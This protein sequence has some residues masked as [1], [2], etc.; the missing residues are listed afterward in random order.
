M[1]KALTWLLIASTAYFITGKLGLLLAIPPGF[2]SAI[3]PA[4]GV[5]LACVLMGH[6]SAAILGLGLGS[7]LINLSLASNNF[8]DISTQG[9]LTAAFIASGAMTQ[10]G[11]GA[12]LFL[13]LLGSS[14]V[15][16]S[17]KNIIRFIFVIALGTSLIAATI[18]V[19]TL[20][21][22]DTISGTN[23]TFS[24]ITWWI[25]D[26]I[27]VVL[28]TPLILTFF[29]QQEQLPI[30]RKW[31]TILPTS[32]IFIGVL[33]LFTLSTEKRH[34][35]MEAEI[36]EAGQQFFFQ[37]DRNLK[38]GIETLAAYSG[39]FNA[40]TKVSW[41][42]FV[43]FS[44]SVSNQRE[45]FDGVGWTEIIEDKE[46]STFIEKIRQEFLPNFNIKEKNAANE[47]ITAIKRERYFPVIYIYPLETNA[48]AVGFN[49]GSKESRL[50]TLLH[51]K[52]SQTP[53][54]TPPIRLV[55]EKGAGLSTIIYYPV[56]RRNYTNNADSN[57]GTFLGYISGVIRIQRLLGDLLDQVKAN[58]F[59]LSLS[60][61][62]DKEQSVLIVEPSE[63]PLQGFLPVIQKFDF[64]GRVYQVEFFANQNFKLTSKDWASFMIL[65]I[66]FIFAAI[67]QA[68]ILLLTGRTESIKLEVA[69]KT[70][71]LLLATKTAEKASRA[72]SEFTANISHELRTPLN[73]IIGLINQCL[74][75]E[76]NEKQRDCLSKARL[77]SET[78]TGIINST[79]DFSKIEAGKLELDFT[80][81]N[82]PHLLNKIAAIF[83]HKAKEG[84]LEFAIDLP[85]SIPVML[86]GDQ[87]RL[88]QIL[89]N[90]LGNAFKF[91]PAGE[92]RLKI[93]IENE[94]ESNTTIC[95]QVIDT[96]IGIPA[97]KQASMFE[98]FHQVDSSTSRKF[99]GTGLGLTISKKLLQ[100]MNSDIH[101]KGQEN[102]GSNFQFS[103]SFELADTKRMTVQDFQLLND[104][105]S[106][107]TVSPAAPPTVL[108]NKKILVVEDVELNQVIVREILKEYQASVSLAG[109]GREA[110]E[111]L[112]Q[113]HNFDLILM[114]IQMP[115]MDGY[116]AT[117]AIREDPGLAHLPI[118]AMT[119]NA[120]KEDVD[121]CLAAGMNAHIAK[122][123]DEKILVSRIIEV[124]SSNNP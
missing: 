57:Q 96:G 100:L 102:I 3:W 63:G 51:A 25:G 12:C 90:L 77:A 95:F 2:A 119:A 75:T 81:F 14:P 112:Q 15:I 89:L 19:S 22:F 34:Q 58:Q 56:I 8:S 26:S 40:S 59:D 47:W 42:E 1:K 107:K 53:Q 21:Q 6:R 54:A 29:S 13:R 117:Q 85:N 9:L 49:L 65:T 24:W 115:E 99:G 121:Q 17:P 45:I 79:L 37:F 62:T 32:L 28:F 55:Q 38:A 84:E 16:D 108:A 71:D 91:T 110:L 33:V 4:S 44:L 73:A 11:V 5:A 105:L 92:V 60:D 27:G 118:I 61:I 114:D 103:I 83:G 104:A 124:L 78:L 101:Y 23:V 20:Y 30:S 50:K 31:Q 111:I 43:Q 106:E 123:I 68:F 41:E 66:G 82:F 94:T 36:N 87:L 46:R 48:A 69:A 97:D 88:E 64:A 122:P 7:F 70:R 10:A 74:K 86:I 18:G 35:Q 76:L 109:N 80:P 39:L 116:E 113:S 72:K 67:L 120:M 93:N 52:A 98:S